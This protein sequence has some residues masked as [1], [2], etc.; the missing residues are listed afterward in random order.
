MTSTQVM[1]I[2]V[3]LAPVSKRSHPTIFPNSCQEDILHPKLWGQVSVSS[4]V[5]LHFVAGRLLGS[6]ACVKGWV[7]LNPAADLQAGPEV[8]PLARG[9]L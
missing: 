8:A 5:P 6:G 4:P 1:S 2:W 3:S 7:T 9:V